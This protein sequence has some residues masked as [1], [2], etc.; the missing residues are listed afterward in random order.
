MPSS[1][2][3]QILAQ[4]IK[5]NQIANESMGRIW[6]LQL[7]VVADNVDPEPARGLRRIRVT[8]GPK[9]GLLT[10]DWLM[11]LAL[12]PGFDP[13]V[14]AIGDSVVVGFFDGDPH[15]GFYLGSLHN[16]TNPGFEQGDPL[17][18]LSNVVPG[19][20]TSYVQGQL[21]K[22]VDGMEH[23]R[24]EETLT[25]ESGRTITL[26]NDAGVQAILSE[27]GTATLKN[28]AGANLTLM[29]NG[30]VVLSDAFGHKWVL[31]GSGGSDWTWDLAGATINCINAGGFQINGKE[32]MVV[33]GRDNDG[34][35]MTYRGY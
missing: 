26:K 35:T 10:T 19:D 9:G 24:T 11:R 31:G 18:D 32:V 14:P 1:P 29:P 25:Q 13:P 3:L 17:K 28:Q 5:T 7:G 21:Q 23:R 20:V 8:T 15:D 33:G 12:V 30:S 6:A 4:S 2:I 27:D 22:T 34:D 16:A